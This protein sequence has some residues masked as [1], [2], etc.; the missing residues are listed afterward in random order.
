MLN[1]KK[2]R[3]LLPSYAG[4]RTDP[5]TTQAVR[6]HLTQCNACQQRVMQMHPS[7]NP[8]SKA[9]LRLAHKV[10]K[11]DHA[12][13]RKSLLFNGLL[14]LALCL[15]LILLMV[16]FE[17]QTIREY[18]GVMM[19]AEGEYPVSAQLNY[20]NLQYVLGENSFKAAL[21]ITLRGDTDHLSLDNEVNSD[22]QSCRRFLCT[23]PVSGQ[24]SEEGQLIYVYADPSL[25]KI[26]LHYGES[27][28]VVKLVSKN[29]SVEEENW[30]FCRN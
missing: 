23:L 24:A 10:V 16:P 1:C 6:E 19:T 21:D 5:K 30:D 29:R 7:V 9:A 25:E 17:S 14:V 2:V 4:G 15:L 22:P 18:H 27:E 3:A 20:R 26:Y 11:E 12:K 28:A 8:P 13:R